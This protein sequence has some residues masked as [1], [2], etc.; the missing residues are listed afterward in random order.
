MIVN[1]DIALQNPNELSGHG[2][3]RQVIAE[4]YAFQVAMDDDGFES[5]QV[6]NPGSD[7]NKLGGTKH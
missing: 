6:R 5:V 7:L 2:V 3:E 1:Q 4:T